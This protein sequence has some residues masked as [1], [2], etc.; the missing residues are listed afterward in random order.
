MFKKVLFLIL[1]ISSAAIAQEKKPKK[2]PKPVLH[3]VSNK[4]VVQSIFSEAVKVEKANDYW[5]N[6]YD[7]DNNILGYAMSSLPYCKNVKGYNNL[8][9]VMILTDKNWVIKKVSLL[10]HWET[11]GYIKKLEKKG[12]FNLW[13]GK[14]LK[15]AK[16]VKPDGYTG[17]TCTAIAVS[18]NVDFLL[19]K[20]SKSLPVKPLTNNNNNTR[21]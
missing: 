21:N 5:F 12:F 17:A 4:D 6:I 20:G 15:Q 7:K 10:T 14:N 19:E 8:T 1:L 3:E 9:P 2:E 18:K 11:I 16:S 13:V